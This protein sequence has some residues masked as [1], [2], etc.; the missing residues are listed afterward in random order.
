MPVL[1]G[2]CRRG[3]DAVD[4]AGEEW[5]VQAQIETEFTRAVSALRPVVITPHQLQL[6][7]V[8]PLGDLPDHALIRRPQ[9][10]SRPGESAKHHAVRR[11]APRRPLPASANLFHPPHHSLG[12]V[13]RVALKV[14]SLASDRSESGLI[15][16]RIRQGNPKVNLPPGR[17]PLRGLQQGWDVLLRTKQLL[18]NIQPGPCRRRLTKSHGSGRDHFTPT[19]EIRFKQDAFETL[20]QNFTGLHKDETGKE[21]V[22]PPAPAP[23]C[24]G[25]AEDATPDHVRLNT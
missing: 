16:E 13:L 23:G 7:S 25:G 22:N 6:V 20:V 11:H 3:V 19:R 1:F 24:R 17:Q 5:P 10:A 18:D 4:A 8:D 15:F 12:S 21:L 9:H 14:Q 2:K